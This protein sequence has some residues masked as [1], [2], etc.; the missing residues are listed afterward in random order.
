MIDQKDYC[1]C[2]N[3]LPEEGNIILPSSGILRGKEK[4]KFTGMII[5][6]NRPICGELLTG[7][8]YELLKS[9]SL[10]L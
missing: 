7:Q 4:T 9:L 1:H 10:E 8:A 2:C 3:K 5:V 6:K